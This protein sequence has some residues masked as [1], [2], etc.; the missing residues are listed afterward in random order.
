MAGL[1]WVENALVAP[2]SGLQRDS[3]MRWQVDGGV[4][5][6]EGALVDSSRHLGD[7]AMN[8][9]PAECR[10][11]DLPVQPGRYL[12][13]GWLQ[14]H[15][16][17]QL[18]T[19]GRLWALRQ[20]QNGI[21]GVVFLRLPDHT[22]RNP[23]GSPHKLPA[24]V[25]MLACFG[26]GGP[27]RPLL[28]VETPTR[29]AHLA[30][31]D[32]I[33]FA[34]PETTAEDN[35]E[36]LAM[37]RQMRE[38]RRVRKGLVLPRLYV[39]RRRLPEQQ[40]RDL[41]EDML[42]ENLIG[43]GYAILYPEQ[44]TVSEQVAAYA[45]ARQIVFS[46]SSAIHLGIG[47]VEADQRIA[48]I[49]RRRPLAASLSR[50][51]AAAGLRQARVIQATRGAVMALQDGRVDAYASFTGLALTDMAQLRDE[52]REAGLC[53]GTDWQLPTEAEIEGRVAEA[54]AARQALWPERVARYV[55]AQEMLP[56]SRP[57]A[58]AIQPTPQPSEA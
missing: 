28:M 16:G 31:P 4:F 54:I 27:R 10:G 23:A 2:C 15:F 43:E 50:E 42:E 22:F 6:A 39:S 40:G 12:F 30:M 32:Q 35:A 9:Q 58:P 52:L 29:F 7:L 24:V 36:Y 1:R 51:I 21:D 17:H 8:I 5:D 53:R 25:D 18:T 46:E 3:Q 49:A 56:G 38:S 45:C 44:M 41:F 47:Q 48:V 34:Q 55:T 19:L 26:I 20:L 37:L 33:L 13:G 11:E 57:V 14:R